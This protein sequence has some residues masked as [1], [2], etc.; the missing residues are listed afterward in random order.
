[1]VSNSGDMLA[2]RVKGEAPY[3]AEERAGWKGY[4]EWEVRSYQRILKSA[5]SDHLPEIPREKKGSREGS[6]EL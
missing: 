4:I 1:M 6:G 5:G 3:F 2:F